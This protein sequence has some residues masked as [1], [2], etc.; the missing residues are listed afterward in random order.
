MIFGAAYVVTAALVAIGGEV[1]GLDRGSAFLGGVLVASIPVA[2]AAFLN[3]KKTAA[4]IAVAVAKELRADNEEL[5]LRVTAT[6]S[7]ARLAAAGEHECLRKVAEL[8]LRLNAITAMAAKPE[9][10]PTP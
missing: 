7:K 1:S 8:E 9:E 3:R 5:R 6:E 10:T 2:I 4:D